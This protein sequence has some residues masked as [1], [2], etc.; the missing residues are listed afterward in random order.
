[1]SKITTKDVRQMIRDY[2]KLFRVKHWIK[3][4]LIFLPIVFNRVAVNKENLITVFLGMVVFSL[5]S[6]VIYVINDI[7]DAEKD[8]MHPTKCKRPIAAGR[9]TKTQAAI[10]A[11]IIFVVVALTAFN[12]GGWIYV[13]VYF[14]INLAYSM[15]LKNYPIIDV[16]ILMLGFVIRVLYGGAIISVKVSD[17][18]FLTIMM[19]AFYFGLG[20]RR[21]ELKA[22]KADTTRK[23]LLYYNHNFLDRNMYVCMAA[24]IVF[25]ALWAIETGY[26]YIIWTVLFVMVICMKYSL[27]VE[28]DSDG[29]P[30]E[31][32]LH[33]KMLLGLCACYGIFVLYI[34]YIATGM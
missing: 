6:S 17:W 12:I 3:N 11:A 28:A 15:K 19:F 10:A 20:K 21:N 26:P 32:L 4:I 5:T 14:C 33:D 2:I 16:T 30:V 29:D 27:D 9:I 18:L 24:G 23:V 7:F 22:V 31:I 13:L 8:K 25:Y 1:M 34:L